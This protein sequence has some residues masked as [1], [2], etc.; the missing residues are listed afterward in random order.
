MHATAI[1]GVLERDAQLVELALVHHG[2][3][4]DVA[5]LLEDARDLDLELRARQEDPFVAGEICIA[6]PSQKVGY[7]IG[8]HP[9]LLPAG[10]GHTGDHSL[11]CE[12][13]QADP[14]DAELAEH[15]PRTAAT[16]A[17]GVGPGLVAGRPRGL[18]P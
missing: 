15:G 8:N 7:G 3:V 10:L 18:H 16:A 14:A 6:E 2:E 5:L 4:L 17:P 9:C 11:V 12:L 13:A 1:V